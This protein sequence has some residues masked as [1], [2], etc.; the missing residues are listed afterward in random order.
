MRQ[1]FGQPGFGRLFGGLT[2][3]MLGDSVMLLVLS[4]W[5]KTLT[6]SNSLAG[7]TFF[8]MVVPALFA[9]LIGVW[10][11]RVRRKPLLVWG[12]L[13]SAAVVA[14]LV[15]VRDEG[16]V[17]LIWAVAFG[18]GISFIVLPAAL[19]G[20]LKELLPE[21]LLVDANASLQ[22]TK[23]GFRLFGPLLGA[24]IF[25]GVGGWVVA[26]I[27]VAS[28]MVAAAVIATIP[29]REERPEPDPSPLRTQL[30]VGLRHLVADRLLK[31]LL[32]G[33]GLTLLVLG[34]TEAAIYALLDGFDRPATY[35]GVLVSVQGAGAVLGGLVVSRLVKT[36][37]EIAVAILGL[38]AM[39][40]GSAG[41][42]AAPTLPVVLA[43][44]TMLGLS[45]P[46]V[47]VSYMTLLQRRTPQRVIGR[48]SAAVE[49]VLTTPQAVSLA[50][51]SLLV[52]LI[53][54]RM[55][56]AIKAM[57]IAVAAS[58]VALCLRDTLGRRPLPDQ[59]EPQVPEPG[60]TPATPPRSTSI[61]D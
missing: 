5:V 57:V 49:V 27:D 60:P 33:F 41:I 12:N 18:Y 14:P 22:T 50:L 25:A 20:L 45:L 48:V 37:G 58:Y 35:A 4:M 11:D 21:H 16:D 38:A 8:F 61:S 7:L 10:I 13:A 26:L 36:Y 30:M 17:W 54:W 59:V 15:L 9:P 42:A 24:A 55:I 6:G 46:F 19:N 56:F 47:M 44:T 39:A 23:E 3:S 43:F 2:A 53:E 52:V 34:F 1:A 28:F 51:G 32:I 40:L 29:V 31:H